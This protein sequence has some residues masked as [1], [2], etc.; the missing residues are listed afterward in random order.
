MKTFSIIM[1][2]MLA[3]IYSLFERILKTIN[4]N[5]C[6]GESVQGCNWTIEGPTEGFFNLED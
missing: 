1:S 2:C 3:G 4:L 5:I 6:V